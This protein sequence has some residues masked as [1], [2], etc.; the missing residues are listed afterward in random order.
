MSEYQYPE[1]YKTFTGECQGGHLITEHETPPRVEITWLDA[2][3]DAIIFEQG[4]VSLLSPAVRK[5][6]GY[7][8]RE[9]D[10]V[11][12]ISPEIIDNAFSGKQHYETQH[13]IL[14]CM[15]ERIDRL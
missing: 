10:D 1:E 4:M 8:L 14:K 2:W 6:I 11:V 9:D 3:S 5:S 7:L 15:V 13:L 12:V